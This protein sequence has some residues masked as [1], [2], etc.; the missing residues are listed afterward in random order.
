LQNEKKK[1]ETRDGAT[2]QRL[3]WACR[4]GTVVELLQHVH[5]ADLV[6]GV[7]ISSWSW[8]SCPGR[9]DF[10]LGVEI[11]SCGRGDRVVLVAGDLMRLEAACVC[12]S[13]RRRLLQGSGDL[14]INLDQRP[15][16]VVSGSTRN[17]GHGCRPRV[18]AGY[19][20]GGRWNPGGAPAVKRGGKVEETWSAQHWRCGG[21][22]GDRRGRGRMTGGSG[23]GEGISCGGTR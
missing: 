12:R 21:D 8:R 4:R 22:A 15:A 10:V 5:D 20:E 14:Q 1:K 17:G 18:H 23:W 11:L 16:R 3:S 19:G 2:S 7:E 9:A 6:L 13:R